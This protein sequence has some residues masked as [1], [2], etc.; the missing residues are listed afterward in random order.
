MLKK[1]KRLIVSPKAFGYVFPIYKALKEKGEDVTIVY[2]EFDG[3]KNKFQKIENFFSKVFTGKNL[4]KGYYFAIQD[5]K[6]MGRFDEVL[7]I[8]PDFLPNKYL[9]SI[10]KVAD[11]FIAYYFDGTNRVPRKKEIIGFFDEVYSYDKEDVKEFG[12]RFI[13]NYIYDSSEVKLSSDYLFFNI[14][15]NDDSYRFG[16]LEKFAKHIKNKNWSYKFISYDP[17]FY[18][19]YKGYNPLIE[20]VPSVIFVDEAKELIKNSK[21]LVEFQ[22]DGQEGLSFRVFESLGFKKKLITTNKDIVNYD[23]YNPQNILV[24]DVDDIN[25]PD[26][27][28]NSP[29]A[30]VNP[31]IVEKYKVENWVDTVFKL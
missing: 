28:V 4:K 27:F 6:K 12:F 29:Y 22:R 31:A 16:L 19:K 3:Y 24:I 1:K 10:K 9:S 15:S 7:I 5:I 14:S 25:I 8:R 18:K 20:V 13:T 30:E 17:T 21:I 26:E 2:L 23:F 11:K